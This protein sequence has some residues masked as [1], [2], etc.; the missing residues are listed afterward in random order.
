MKTLLIGGR[1]TLLKSVLGVDLKDRKISLIKWDN[2]LASKGKCG[3]GVSSFYALNRALIFKWIWRFRTQSSSLWAR[4]IKVIHGMDGKIGC[5]PTASL[6]SNWIDIPWKDDVPL[7]SLFPRIYALESIKSIT[8]AAKTSQPGFDSSLRRMLRGGI[9]QHQMA[10]LCLK[11]EDIILPN[12]MDRWFWSLSGSGEFSVAVVRNFI[13]DH[14][15]VDYIPKTRW[16]KAAPKKINIHAWRVKMDNL[17]MRFN[18]SRRAKLKTYLEGVFYVT[19]WTILVYMLDVVLARPRFVRA[20]KALIISKTTVEDEVLEHIRD[21]LTP[22]E[23]WDTLV[24]LEI[25]ELDL[26]SKIGEARM[27]RIIIHGLKQDYRSFVAAVQGWPTQPSLAEFENLLASREALAKQ[28]RDMSIN[29]TSKTDAEAL[30]VDNKYKAQAEYEIKKEGDF[31]LTVTTTNQYTNHL[32]DWIVDSG[33]SNHLTG[34]KEKLSNP[35]KSTTQI[36]AIRFLPRLRNEE[37]L[38]YVPQLTTEW[39]YVLFSPEEVYVFK[40]FQTPSI[41]FLKGHKNESVYVLSVEHAFVEKTKDT[42]NADLWHHRFGHVG[43]DKLELM[44][45]RGLVTRLP[46]LEV[47]RDIVCAGCQYG[48]THQE[49]FHSSSYRARAPLDLVHLDVWGPAKHASIKGLRYAVTFIDDYSRFTWIYF[50]KEKSK[51][52]AKFK[53]FEVE[54]E[55]ETSHKGPEN[56]PLQDSQKLTKNVGLSIT[57]LNPTKEMTEAASNEEHV[58]SNSYH[59]ASENEHW[60]SAMKA[61]MDA[62]VSNQTWELV[63]KPP[64]VKP[65]SCKWVYKVKQKADGTVDRYKAR[66]VARGFSQQVGLDYKDTFIPVAKITTIRVLLA[67][68]ASKDWKLWQ[69][70]VHNAFLYGE[71]D[72]VNYMMQ[73]MGFESQEH[74]EHVFDASLFVKKLGEKIVFVLVYVDDLIISGDVDEEVELL[75]SN[76]STRFKIKDLERLKNSLGLE[77]DYTNDAMIL[78]Q[79][80]Y[81]IDLLHKFHVA[82]CKPATVPMDRNVKLYA[83]EGKKLDD[84]TRYRKM[85][86]SLIYL[87]LTRPDIAFVVG[88]LSRFMQDPRKPHMVAMKEVLKYIKVTVGKGLRF[89]SDVEPKLFGCCDADYAGDVNTRRSTTGYVFLYESSPISWCSKRQ[90]TVSLSTTE[91][92]YRDAAMA[93]QECVWL[94]ELLRNLNQRVVYPVQLWCDNISVIKLAQNPVFHA[95]TKRIEVHYHFIREKVLNDEISLEVI[96]SEEQV[97]DAL[98]K[99]L[100]GMKLKQ[101]SARVHLRKGR[102]PGVEGRESSRGREGVQPILDYTS[103]DPITISDEKFDMH[104]LIQQMGHD[105][106]KR[107]V[108]IVAVGVTG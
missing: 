53:E 95:R 60:I 75:K 12:M 97:A 101:H 45:K 23:A 66:L 102:S 47:R 35:V 72:H 24:T 19:W 85:V 87:T 26:Q 42:Q 99:G 80:K 91:A 21:S 7:K 25:G 48:K 70:D 55:R 32:N 78:H 30:Y 20:G 65:V 90:P 52:L 83:T 89:G 1:L 104:D 33:C 68:A 103:T 64:G 57:K 67:L 77:L 46:K 107:V 28:L 17:P 98:T 22:K 62:L 38:L 76:M 50:V 18:L 36:E 82:S 94:V 93:T 58:A 106:I 14:T 56:E 96:G 40:E 43:Y 31:A 49:L 2:V 37:N 9:E 39:K 105:K 13:N 5:S 73:P 29:S 3:L 63:P 10:D 54:A 100:T 92:E 15:L 4:V 44:M 61:K 6:S 41:P 51:V 16:I 71:L 79:R 88:F 74:P 81:T 27:K 84:P 11:M 34:D 108:V 8:V 86:G 69:M 59:E